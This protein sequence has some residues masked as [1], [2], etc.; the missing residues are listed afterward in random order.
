L[1]WCRAL[2]VGTNQKALKIESTDTVESSRGGR[3]LLKSRDTNSARS[4]ESSKRALYNSCSW[5]FPRRMSKM[6]AIAG[7]N[8]AI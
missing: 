6:N 5:R 8:S 1:R 4:A 2:S 7:R 3:G